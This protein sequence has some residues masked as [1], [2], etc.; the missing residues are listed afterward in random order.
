MRLTGLS[1]GDLTPLN[2]LADG[3]VQDMS[4]LMNYV[5]WGG[6]NTSGETIS[7]DLSQ[8]VPASDIN[9]ELAK[10]AIG[11]VAWGEAGAGTSRT[12]ATDLISYVT[13]AAMNTNGFSIICYLFCY[14]HVINLKML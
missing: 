7:R 6:V 3:S 9:C 12:P 8:Y 14:E 2:V 1:Q 10:K 4:T 5:G 13:T 11:A